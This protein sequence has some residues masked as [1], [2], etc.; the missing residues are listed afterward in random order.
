MLRATVDGFLCPRC[1]RTI[2]IWKKFQ[3]KIL[4][5]FGVSALFIVTFYFDNFLVIQNLPANT[6]D[7]LK[8][9]DDSGQYGFEIIIVNMQ[10]FS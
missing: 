3:D 1:G 5:N 4:E 9:Q 2:I 10:K 7:C 6:G 8:K